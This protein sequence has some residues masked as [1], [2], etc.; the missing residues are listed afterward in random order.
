MDT[1]EVKTKV[2]SKCGREL[3][4]SEFGRYQKNKDGY[5]YQ[6]KECHNQWYKKYKGFYVYIILDKNNEI[7]YVGISN[8]FY[9]R[10]LHHI[11]G[12]VNSTKELFNSGEWSCIKYLDVSNLVANEMELK[13]LENILIEIYEP[14]LN[15]VKNIIKDIN[16]DRI[17]TLVA[18]LHNMSQDWKVFKTNK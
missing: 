6:C 17:F 1:K 16:N 10:L 7:V 8:N 5:H 13:V 11:S 2:C 12:Y 14:K 15:K 3:E 9:K 18:T 4:I